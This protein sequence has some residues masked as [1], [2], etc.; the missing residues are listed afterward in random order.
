MR[1]AIFDFDG[2]LYANETFPILMDHLK[3]H[4][5]YHS[6]YKRFLR[7]ILPPYIGSKLKIY[8]KHKMRERSMQIYLAALDQL[9]KQELDTYFEEIAEKMK[10]NFNQQVIERLEQHIS[11]NDHVMLVSGA[12]TPL[13]QSVTKELLFHT[14]IGTDI[15][16]KEQHVDSKSPIY[17]I[18]ASRKNEKIQ[19]AL[20]NKDIDWSN[21][22]AY[23]DSFSD[24]PVFELVGN[25]VAVKPEPRLESTAKNRG[26][27]II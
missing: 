27:E 2:T 17:H 18:Q 19:T 4:P 11:D 7:T 13:L 14:I 5:V 22:F 16:L 6:K 1:V 15:P 12:Y 20:A 23:A 25:P 9:S 26:W 21:S 8:P 10:T 3:N 24:L